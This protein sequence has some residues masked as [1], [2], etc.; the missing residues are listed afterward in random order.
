MSW[1][2]LQRVNGE[3]I[4]GQTSSDVP[5]EG[6]AIAQETID[7]FTRELVAV[8][9]RIVVATVCHSAPERRKVRQR[10]RELFNCNQV[11]ENV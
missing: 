6:V 7:D 8:N 1:Y 3:I 4:I 11:K 10:A 5:K 9:G 2:K